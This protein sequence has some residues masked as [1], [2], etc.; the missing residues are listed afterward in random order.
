MVVITGNRGDQAG[1][2]KAKKRAQQLEKKR[3]AH[4]Q[5]QEQRRIAKATKLA[6]AKA[7]QRKAAAE[8][9]QRGRRRK[10][11]ASSSSSTS[12]PNS[13]GDWGPESLSEG[14][15]DAGMGETK[16]ED[17]LSS[18]DDGGS[19]EEG[20]DDDDSDEED[21]ATLA[22]A[23]FAPGEERNFVAP[24]A[25]DPLDVVA[26]YRKMA[27]RNEQGVQGSDGVWRDEGQWAPRYYYVWVGANIISRE[28]IHEF[29]F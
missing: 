13:K 10:R 3:A 4:Y 6:Q 18:E 12:S 21:E 20:H 7:A 17:F 27:K 5:K 25:A 15:D 8:A 11:G 22:E 14:E 9:K 1:A 26:R 19:F 16:L 2:I 24:A 29:I 28:N 23:L